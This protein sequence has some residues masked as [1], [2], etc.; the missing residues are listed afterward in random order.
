M[1]VELFAADA[2]PLL[3][4]VKFL[5]DKLSGRDVFVAVAGSGSLEVRSEPDNPI[6]AAD[7]AGLLA[8]AGL[9]AAGVHER[10]EWSIAQA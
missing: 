10:L 1:H 2:K 5:T 4:Y 3:G 9:P 6:T 7:V 8:G